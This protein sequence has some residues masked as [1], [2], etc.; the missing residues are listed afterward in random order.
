MLDSVILE[1]ESEQ[2][3]LWEQ[4]FRNQ[5]WGKYPS[6]DL[7]RFIARRFYKAPDRSKIKILELGCGTGANLWFLARE[8][9]SVHGIDIAQSA[10]TQA[11]ER[12]DQECAGWRG[13]LVVGDMV[14]LP[15]EDDM[16]DAVIDVEAVYANPFTKSQVIYREAARVCKPGGFLYSRTFAQGCWGDGT[17]RKAGHQAW[18]PTEGPFAG[19]GLSRFT[20]QQDIS[21]LVA[22]FRV[23][24]LELI[25]RTVNQLKNEIREW[26]IVGQKN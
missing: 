8:G 14:E 12:L 2:K 15:F 17:G 7:I 5:T 11:A 24:E 19:M 20:D 25:S 9:F 1:E 18:F 4:V 6:E 13:K 22:G 23:T 3:K 21:E 16:F 10:I 26:I